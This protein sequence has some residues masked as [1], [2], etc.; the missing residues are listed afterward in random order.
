MIFHDHAVNH[1]AE[2]VYFGQA[3]AYILHDAAERSLGLPSGKYDVPLLL[4]S[5]QYNNDGSLYFPDGDMANPY[6]EVM[7][8]DI[9]HVNGQ[10]WPYF[11]VE[12]R[13]YR[14]RL[15]DSSI[16]RA[17]RLYLERDTRVGEKLN[18][19]V[20]GSDSGLLTG[21]QPTKDLYISMGERW[22]V[23]IDF[24]K[25]QGQNLTLRNTCG[26]AADEDYK[27]TDRVMRFV[28]GKNPVVD[29]S[30]VPSAL[31]AV[32]FPKDTRRIDHHFK[33][34]R[35]N[36]VWKINNVTFSDVRNRILARPPR[37]TVEVWELENAGGG[38]HPVHLHLV[39]FRI[40][41]RVGGRNTILPYEA[42][43]L[44]DVV[45]LEPGE[46]ATVEARYSPVSITPTESVSR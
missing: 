16:T 34:D 30:R 7:Y 5:K 28:V 41:K 11:N 12:P 4:S 2:N 26:V 17:F 6:R 38:A 35:I 39:D 33:F 31:R 46:T 45:L 14:F 36:G 37:G 27:Y 42:A 19:T 8:G 25:Y 22:E 29:N 9:I 1:T 13:K 44:K 3:G 18:F 20:I 15:L 43:G 23:I 21:P 10:P 40:L 24:S 32:P